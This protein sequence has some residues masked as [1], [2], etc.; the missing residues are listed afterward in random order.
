MGH[1]EVVSVLEL[2][3]GS[4]DFETKSHVQGRW[5]ESEARML[6]DAA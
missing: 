4:W 2:V 5:I 6:I 3:T 1:T